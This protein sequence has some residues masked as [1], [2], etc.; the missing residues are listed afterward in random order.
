MKL[1]IS[2]G[3]FNLKCILYYV[4]FA[5]F[6]IYK[7]LVFYY[8]ENNEDILDKNKLFHSFCFFLGYLLNIFPALNNQRNSKTHENFI[9]NESKG[10]RSQSIK[11]IYNKTFVKGLSTKDIIIFFIICFILLITDFIENFS[12]IV[13]NKK[14]ENEENKEKYEQDFIII[15]FIVIFLLS[16]YSRDVFYKHQNITF[17]I[18]ILLEVIKTIF[19]LGGKYSLNLEDIFLIFLNIIYSILYAIYYIYMKELM[20]YKYISPYKSNFMIGIINLPIIIIIYIII[21]F[22]P[23][24]NKDN[25]YYYDSIFDL[26]KNIRNLNIM[27]IILLIT[28]PFAYGIILLL[29]NK[30]IYNFTIYHIYIPSLLDNFI[31]IIFKDSEFTEKIFLSLS[32]FIE[33]LMILVFLEIIELNFCGLNQNLK[34]NI[35]IRAYNESSFTIEG[36]YNEYDN[37]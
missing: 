6:Q 5:I 27:N 10:K 16:K 31:T 8:D 23:L 7:S 11:Y 29:T 4:L 13:I 12:S 20:K 2:L 32:F 35:V 34:R 17:L 22:T 28:L 15:E 14:K 18:L 24:G 36:E 25:D 30:I 19:L 3:M 26:F 33:L 9:M 1:C 21:S 37:E